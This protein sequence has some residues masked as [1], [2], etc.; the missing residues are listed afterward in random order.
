[1]AVEVVSVRRDTWKY[2]QNAPHVHGLHWRAKCRQ[3]RAYMDAQCWY[4]RV[5][6]LMHHT[7]TA[8]CWDVPS[9]TILRTLTAY[10]EDASPQCEPPT[11][12]Q[13]YGAIQAWCRLRGKKIADMPDKGTVLMPPPMEFL[14]QD[15]APHYKAD[16][17]LQGEYA[18]AT[19]GIAEHQHSGRHI[20]AREQVIEHHYVIVSKA[21][22]SKV[23][24]GVHS[25]SQPGVDKTLKVLQRHYKFHGYT[26]MKLRQLEEHVIQ[27]CD[28]CQTSVPRCGRHTATTLSPRNISLP[29]W[30]WT[31]SVSERASCAKVTLWT[32]AS[33]LLTE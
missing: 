22:A 7:L 32:V 25:Y 4:Q 13:C 14:F 20:G 6:A 27:R 29:Q 26:P 16:P 3:A 23:I 21:V 33:S 30:E 8:D 5:A 18:A 12:V 1:M 17:A 31:L 28:T 19:S 2:A 9:A 24:Q 10:Y 15:W 11:S